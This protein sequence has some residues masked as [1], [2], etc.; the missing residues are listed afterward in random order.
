[1]PLSGLGAALEIDARSHR[2]ELRR[3]LND[4]DAMCSAAAEPPLTA[5]VVDRYTDPGIPPE[6]DDLRR[7]EMSR[8]FD[9]WSPS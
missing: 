9:H 6:R 5:L 3:I 8:V 2:D 7:H 4:V 1:M